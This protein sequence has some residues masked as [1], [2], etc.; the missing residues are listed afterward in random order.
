M[1]EKRYASTS[2]VMSPLAQAEQERAALQRQKEREAEVAIKEREE[3]MTEARFKIRLVEFYSKHNP[4][5]ADSDSVA[6]TVQQW[7]GK[8][9][10]LFDSLNKKYKVEVYPAAEMESSV[11]AKAEVMSATASLR[12]RMFTFYKRNNPAKA[13]YAEIDDVLRKYRGREDELLESLQ[14]KYGSRP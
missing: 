14:R 10:E 12:D 3:K 5:K 1:L 4:S 11:A 7:R 13:Q 6:R 2:P 9:E 8:E